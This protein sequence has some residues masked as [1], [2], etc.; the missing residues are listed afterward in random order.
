MR[1]SGR[2]QKISPSPG[3]D[4]RTVQ[5][6]ERYGLW[7][8]LTTNLQEVAGLRMRGANLQS[9]SLPN[10]I[11][12]HR[13]TYGFSFRFLIGT[14]SDKTDRTDKIRY[15]HSRL[16]LLHRNSIT[17]LIARAYKHPIDS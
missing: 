7:H 3:F 8:E 6:V 11:L 2:E 14:L 4:P 16:C 10:E 13:N 17:R 5:Q 12:T 1:Q 15:L 9:T